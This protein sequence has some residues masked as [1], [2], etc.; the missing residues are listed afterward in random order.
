MNAAG[1]DTLYG[2][3]G[4]DSLTAGLKSGTAT[5]LYG[6]KGNDKLNMK[7][8]LVSTFAYADD[9]QRDVITCSAQGLDGVDV[10]RRDYIKNPP[11]CQAITRAGQLVKT[12][13]GANQDLLAFQRSST[14]RQLDGR[15]ISL[16]SD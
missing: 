14:G 4:D 2:G 3:P 12:Y 7:K 15:M 1:I 10:D 6:G 16:A 5:S 11:A 9:G 13:R 8:A